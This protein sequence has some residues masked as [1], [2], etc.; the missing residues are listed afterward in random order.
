[1]F[2]H[3]TFAV[4]MF[5]S[6]ECL[7]PYEKNDFAKVSKNLVRYKSENIVLLDHQNNYVEHLKE[8]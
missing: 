3:Y 6:K 1:M 8:S 4:P 5:G 2:D 7:D